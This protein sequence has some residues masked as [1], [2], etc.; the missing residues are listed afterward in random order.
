[1]EIKLLAPM[2]LPHSAWRIV[3]E[4]MVKAIKYFFF[5]SKKL[6]PV[7]NST[8]LALVPK[9]PNP[10]SIKDFRSISCC[11]IVYKCVTKI[12]ANKLK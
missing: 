9:C 6:L 1:M 11:S 4:D 2:D 5:L 12:M 10:S 7:F 3:G 8:I